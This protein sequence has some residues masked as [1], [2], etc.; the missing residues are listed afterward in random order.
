MFLQPVPF[1]FPLQAIPFLWT[2]LSYPPTPSLLLINWSPRSP[3]LFPLN[4]LLT[5]SDSAGSIGSVS[6]YFIRDHWQKAHRSC[7]LMQK[8]LTSSQESFKTLPLL[9]LFRHN[10]MQMRCESCFPHLLCA[11]IRPSAVFVDILVKNNLQSHRNRW[12]I[13]LR[14]RK[15]NFSGSRDWIFLS[16]KPSSGPK[17]YSILWRIGIIVLF[18]NL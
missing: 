9:P 6:T 3:P 5:S 4:C 14:N 15:P 8:L 17:N 11:N 16:N 18:V 13:L 1:D 12:L 10:F 7:R 2:F